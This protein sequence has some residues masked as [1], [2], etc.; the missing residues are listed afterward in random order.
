VER[1][2]GRLCTAGW[3]QLANQADRRVSVPLVTGYTL[4]VVVGPEGPRS[5][6]R[7]DAVNKPWVGISMSPHGQESNG[8][9]FLSNV[10]RADESRRM[11]QVTRRVRR[12]PGLELVSLSTTPM[13]R[14]TGE[15]YCILQWRLLIRQEIDSSFVTVVCV[16]HMHTKVSQGNCAVLAFL[17][18]RAGTYS[19]LIYFSHAAKALPF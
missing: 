8:A 7:K 3:N 17:F 12:W 14:N 18:W 10:V 13:P 9:G 16:L 11:G 6:T 19:P 15:S 1:P 5:E 2:V 4:V